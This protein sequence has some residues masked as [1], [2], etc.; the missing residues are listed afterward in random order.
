MEV[1]SGSQTSFWFDNWSSLGRLYETHRERG[2][3]NMGI[4][5]G[6]TVA[7]AIGIRR[8]RHHRNEELNNIE[9]E[10]DKFRDLGSTEDDV[11]M[12][13]RSDGTF[14]SSFSSSETWKQIRHGGQMKEWHKGVWFSGATSK[15]SFLLWLATHNRLTMGDRM[16]AWNRGVISSC[17]FCQQLME[18]RDHLFFECNFSARIWEVLTRKLLQQRYTTSFTDIL[19]LLSG[20]SFDKTTG[21]IL[22]YVYQATVHKIWHERNRRRHGELPHSSGYLIA[23]IDRMVR[24]RISSIHSLDRSKLEDGL[25]VWFGSRA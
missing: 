12:W 24:N 4:R 7:D 5:A 22:C 17:S 15:Y 10:L 3:I 20:S 9:R 21:F 14:K 16:I 25:I 2:F 1:R 18:S 13:R 8:R 11:A 19:M 6:A 23:F